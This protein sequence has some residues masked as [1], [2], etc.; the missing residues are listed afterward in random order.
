MYQIFLQHDTYSFGQREQIK[1]SC[2]TKSVTQWNKVFNRDRFSGTTEYWR[3]SDDQHK[4][5]VNANVFTDIRNTGKLREINYINI[6][7]KSCSIREPSWKVNHP[8]N[9][10]IQGKKYKLPSFSKN[11]LWIR[12][13]EKVH[14]FTE[15]VWSPMVYNIHTTQLSVYFVYP[16]LGITSIS[17]WRTVVTC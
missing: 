5:T 10:Y 4:P 2:S 8:G 13:D 14:Y 16:H 17:K 9:V 7:I 1:I 11:A 15:T 6:N 3:I 12:H